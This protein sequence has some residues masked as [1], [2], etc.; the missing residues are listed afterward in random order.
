MPGEPMSKEFDP[1]IELR[2]LG[3]DDDTIAAL[4]ADVPTNLRGMLALRGGL[5][6]GPRAAIGAGP[7]TAEPLRYERTYDMGMSAAEILLRRESRG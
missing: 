5:A 6:D 7:N 3:L 1:A 2:A 4:G